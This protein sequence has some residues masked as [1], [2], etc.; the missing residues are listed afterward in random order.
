MKR[1]LSPKTSATLRGEV[2]RDHN[3]F[4]R[5]RSLDEMHNHYGWTL[6]RSPIVPSRQQIIIGDLRRLEPGWEPYL[7]V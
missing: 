5:D 3:G 6:R 4:K 7:E 1:T 2:F